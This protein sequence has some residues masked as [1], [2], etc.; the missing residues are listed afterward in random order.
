[1]LF[2]PGARFQGLPD[3]GFGV[4]EVRN[5][6]ERRR[7]IHAVI[8]PALELLAEDLLARLNPLAAEPLHH[9]LPRLDWPRGYRPFCTWLALSRAT[10]GY[11]AGAQLNVGVHADHVSIRL[12]WDT[13]AD[14]FG[15]FEFLSRHGEI[16]EALTRVAGEQGLVFR[17][18][19]SAP[20]PRG[21]QCVF[22]SGVDLRGSLDEISRRGVWWEL[23]QRHEVPAE[24]DHVC[25]PALGKEA[26]A[27]L[28]ALLP[29][30][31][32]IAGTLPTEG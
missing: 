7:E 24:L 14:L 27:V 20:W 18:F 6:N 3:E 16:G 2:Q 4:F 9:H 28:G 21:S 22:E 15:R 29:I 30:Y 17:V 11:Q 12:G 32:R 23:G 13:S 8:H 31:E 10:Q 1:M 25:S 19:A 26:V 5:D